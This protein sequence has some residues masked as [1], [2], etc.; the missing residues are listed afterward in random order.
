MMLH[1]HGSLYL[2][3]SVSH[4]PLGQTLSRC[5]RFYNDAEFWVPVAANIQYSHFHYLPFKDIFIC[6]NN[7]FA[8]RH[9]NSVQYIGRVCLPNDFQNAHRLL[10]QD[11]LLPLYSCGTALMTFLPEFCCGYER[12]SKNWL[13]LAWKRKPSTCRNVRVATVEWNVI[14]YLIIVFVTELSIRF[15]A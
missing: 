9:W 3:L 11:W 12:F 7:I 10:F 8:N 1:Y 6:K 4:P 14:D 2:M 15:L 5:Q 13:C